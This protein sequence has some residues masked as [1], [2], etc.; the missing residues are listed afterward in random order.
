MGRF[1]LSKYGSY[2]FSRSSRS[3]KTKIHLFERRDLRT[4]SRTSFNHAFINI[5]IRSTVN[6]VL[7]AVSP[8]ETGNS[9]FWREMPTSACKKKANMNMRS[10]YFIF[11]QRRKTI[12]QD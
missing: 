11:I 2:V 8:I 9:P 4:K 5:A 12:T 7:T 3:T 6:F 10:S 1:N